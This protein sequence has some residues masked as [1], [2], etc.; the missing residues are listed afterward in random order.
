[1]RYNTSMLFFKERFWHVPVMSLQT[2]TKIAE[3]S[4]F[5]IDPRQLKIVA[6]YC[7]GPQL[8]IR[9]AIL[10]ISDIREI[11]SLG[12]IVDSSDVLMSPDDLVRLKEIISY[13]FQLDD[14]KVVDENGRKLGTVVNF[15]ID[16]DSLF[17]VKLQVQPKLFAAFQQTELTVD[18]S[19]IIQVTD[20]EIIVQSPTVKDK[21]KQNVSAPV[22]ENPFKTAQ[23][24]S[25]DLIRNQK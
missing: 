18:R 8:D 19:Q 24:E 2:G 10:N 6:F 23:P 22:L 12:V 17:I 14:K 25:I 4:D 5:I 3:T 9:P 20:K 7:E 21:V 15:T 16:S 1:M 11:S 13:N